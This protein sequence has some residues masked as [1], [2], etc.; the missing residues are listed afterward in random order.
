M[1]THQNEDIKGKPGE[2]GL[3]DSPVQMSGS[4]TG[5]RNNRTLQWQ[6]AAAQ[7][8][9]PARST[10]LHHGH[11]PSATAPGAQSQSVAQL[12]IR[13]LYH[14]P[15]LRASPP[16]TSCPPFSEAHV[17]ILTEAGGTAMATASTG[18]TMK[19]SPKGWPIWASR[20]P[21]YRP[22]PKGRVPKVPDMTCET[23]CCWLSAT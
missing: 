18:N 19:N 15:I 16:L 7:T 3:A 21:G 20:P 8:C 13:K 10:S 23:R 12:T 1:A 11:D 2:S 5:K 6:G 22:L 14:D 4:A 17:R 9:A